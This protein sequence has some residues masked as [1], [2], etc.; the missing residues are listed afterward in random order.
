SQFVADRRRCCRDD[1]L[2]LPREN[3]AAAKA[4]IRLGHRR[5]NRRP[6]LAAALNGMLD[7]VG[8][9]GV[10]AAYG[11][12][13]KDW[14]A[15]NSGLADDRIVDDAQRGSADTPLHRLGVPWVVNRADRGWQTLLHQSVKHAPVLPLESLA[16]VGMLLEAICYRPRRR[17]EH[18]GL[19][20]SI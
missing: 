14:N 9:I 2:R 7:G 8:E 5:G 6:Y 4:E 16:H 20:A 12:E 19:A 1:R 13:I 15:G 3:H 17:S 10:V 18:G 11:T